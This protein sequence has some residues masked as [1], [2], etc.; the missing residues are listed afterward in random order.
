MLK[1]AGKYPPKRGN[2]FGIT[3]TEG[4]PYTR[5]ASATDCHCGAFLDFRFERPNQQLLTGPDV[6]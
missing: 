3:V 4:L 6:I 2:I 1:G 5:A